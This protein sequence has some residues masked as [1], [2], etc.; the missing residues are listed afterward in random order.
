MGFALNIQTVKASGTIHIRAD[1][2]VE[3]T[4][5][6]QRDGDIYT[7]TDNIY[8]EIVVQRSNIIIDGNR[9]TQQGTR[10]YGSEGIY[11]SD[12]NNVTIK[13]TNIM[14]FDDGLY[15]NSSSNN[16]IFGNNITNNRWC[17]I[18]LDKSSNN[19]IS[20]NN[21]TVREVTNGEA[22]IVIAHSSN[23]TLSGNNIRN[24]YS[25]IDFYMGASNNIIVENNVTNNLYGIRLMGVSSNNSIY[26]NN[27]VNDRL[28]A[29]ASLMNAWDNGVEGNYWNDYTGDDQ[30]GDGIGDAPYV[31]DKIGQDNY[32]LINSWVPP[33]VGEGVPFWAQWWLWVIVAMVIIMSAGAVYLKKRRPTPSLPPPSESV[34]QSE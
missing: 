3:G 25:G 10:A 27:F 23:N 19:T 18:L 13:N 24:S 2:S 29:W 34:E 28:Q 14:E 17:G 9:Y 31:I 12:I 26:H 6:I 5:K 15:L 22:G 20:G 21:V 16:A 7:F 30:D 32:P 8:R 11:L 33:Q 1:G 4:D